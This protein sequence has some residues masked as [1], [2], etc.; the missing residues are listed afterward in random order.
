[1]LSALRN[2][3][4]RILRVPPRPEPPIGA[5][6]SARTFRAGKNDYW[7]RVIRWSMAQTA[8]ALGVIV[9]FAVV[10]SMLDDWETM[11]A[12]SA[13]VAAGPTAEEG[14]ASIAPE[15]KPRPGFG[16]RLARKILGRPSSRANQI[17]DRAPDWTITALRLAKLAGVGFFILQIP[18]T[19]AVVRLDFEM[20][21]YI[22]TD[23]S[24]RVRTGILALR[25]ATMSFANLQQVE[26]Q[27]GP[28][29]RALGLADV[30]VQSAGGGGMSGQ[31]QQQGME[32]LKT[33]VFRGVENAHEVRDLILAR[34]RRFREAGLGDPDEPA[35]ASQETEATD[36]RLAAAAELL[37]EAKA[38][39]RQLA[40]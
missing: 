36:H 6:G 32:S 8:A 38:L 26:V 10:S 40:P 31:H 19:F 22:V 3:L 16:G 4:L 37:A 12:E 25:E 35:A 5:P 28:L 39:R 27:Q 34:L 17:A 13:R 21:W 20:H 33:V 14:A 1:M 18:V 30:R 2:Q 29:Q 7:L 15:E 23:R 11:R 24:L 9:S